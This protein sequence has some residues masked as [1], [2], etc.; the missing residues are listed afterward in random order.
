MAA[1][2][3]RRVA[4]KLLARRLMRKDVGK[5]VKRFGG[6]RPSVGRVMGDGV[7]VGG[8]SPWLFIVLFVPV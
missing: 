2:V 3:E 7:I 4:L 5:R 1:D 6:H 8:G